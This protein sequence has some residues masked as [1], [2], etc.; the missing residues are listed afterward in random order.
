MT[1]SAAI[2]SAPPTAGFT[3]LEMLVV[4]ALI[5]ITMA[6]STLALRGGSGKAAALQPL[7]ARVAAD[8]RSARVDAMQRSR[9]VEVSFDGRARTYFVEGTTS[10]KRFP[11]HVGFAFST[12][13]DGLRPDYASRLVFF[14]DGSS[15]GG[16]LTL[17]SSSTPKRT[18][19]LAVDW[20]TGNVREASRTP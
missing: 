18:I 16:Q 6:A 15:T 11:D 5:G 1:R 10:A 13:S 20:L 7:A 3:L 19:V 9:P 17:T 4:L 2:R 12:A 8:L 14:P